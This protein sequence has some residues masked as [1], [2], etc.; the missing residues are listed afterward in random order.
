MEALAQRSGVKL[1]H[2]PYKGAGPAVNAVAIGEVAMAIASPPSVLG[3]IDEGKLQALAVGSEKRLAQLP[4]VPTLAEAGIAGDVLVPT[5][6]ALTAPAGTAP[7]IIAKLN[8]EMRRAVMAADVA[9][10]LQKSGLIPAGG[11]PEQMADT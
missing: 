3:L 6:L 5:F 2:V 7:K 9:E 11:A 8:S 4:N 10:R 1:Q